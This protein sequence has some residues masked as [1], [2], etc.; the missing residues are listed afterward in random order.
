MPATKTAVS[1]PEEFLFDFDWAEDV[2]NELQNQVSDDWDLCHDSE[3]LPSS[4]LLDDSIDSSSEDESTE[5]AESVTED[6]TVETDTTVVSIPPTGEVSPV[7]QLRQGVTE[8]FHGRESAVARDENIHHF[9]WSGYPVYR[10]SSTTAAESLAIIF[11]GPKVPKENDNLRITS[12]LRRAYRYIDPVMVSLER[13]SKG[14]FQYRGSSLQ[15]AATGHV[16]K[17]YTP[18]GRWVVDSHSSGS[19]RLCVDTGVVGVYLSP[20]FAIG[21]GFVSPSL[22]PNI[23]NWQSAYHEIAKSRKRSSLPKKNTWGRLP[24]SPLRQSMTVSDDV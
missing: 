15:N 11:S 23:L 6:D 21:N 13:T 4:E 12:I 2:E 8:E 9:N 3:E 16:F 22:I 7:E 24:P 17:F 19:E 1:P 20:H 14:L 10:S 18:H 5:D